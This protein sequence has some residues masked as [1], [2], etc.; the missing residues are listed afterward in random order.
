LFLL[1]EPKAALSIIGFVQDTGR[2]KLTLG[3]LHDHSQI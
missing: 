2:L 1:S 3:K